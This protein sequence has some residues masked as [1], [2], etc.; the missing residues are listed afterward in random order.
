MEQSSQSIIR[1]IDSQ[2]SIL[3][4]MDIGPDRNPEL[5]Y[6]ST[7]GPAKNESDGLGTEL[8]RFSTIGESLGKYNSCPISKKEFREK[9]IVERVN[10]CGHYFDPDALAS[11][12]EDKNKCPLCGKK[13][14]NT[15]PGPGATNS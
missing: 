3:K 7:R 9:S 10:G 2:L 12:L 8:V 15:R 1:I 5:V 6:A 4:R 14:T 13:V 11:W